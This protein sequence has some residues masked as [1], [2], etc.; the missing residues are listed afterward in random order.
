MQGRRAADLGTPRCFQRIVFPRRADRSG[1][2]SIPRFEASAGKE[3]DREVCKG[4][5]ATCGRDSH[6]Q[7]SMQGCQ[8]LAAEGG[9]GFSLFSAL[10]FAQAF[11]P[12]PPSKPLGVYQTGPHITMG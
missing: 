1:R 11:S 6:R 7:N 3:S 8:V 12:S 5:Y 9:E 10:S 2:A 4:V